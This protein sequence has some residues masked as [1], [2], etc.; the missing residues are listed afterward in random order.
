VKSTRTH[1]STRRVVAVTAIACLLTLVVAA[2]IRLSQNSGSPDE[3]QESEARLRRTLDGVF[4][5]ESADSE[6]ARAV[7]ATIQSEV[8]IARDTYLRDT[9]M[10]SRACRTRVCKVTMK[11][12]NNEQFEA[13]P[14]L[15]LQ[16][17]LRVV[18]FHDPGSE[19]AIFF[20]RPG[21]VLPKSS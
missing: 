20:I 9:R 5:S 1:V 19:T 3:A 11:G 15:A 2:R 17:G 8:D 13:L 21:T 7:E 10:I 4:A 18:A 6:W 16:V 14:R 12:V